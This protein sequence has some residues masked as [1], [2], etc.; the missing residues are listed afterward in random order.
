[1]HVRRA[2]FTMDPGLKTVIRATGKYTEHGGDTLTFGTGTWHGRRGT[3]TGT[4]F[5][6]KAGKPP[7]VSVRQ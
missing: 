6:K 4:T 3:P 5:S 2:V 1:M 7:H